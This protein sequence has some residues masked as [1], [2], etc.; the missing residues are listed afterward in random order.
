[1]DRKK[2]SDGRKWA[3]VRRRILA[4][5][6]DR[7]KEFLRLICRVDEPSY[8]VIACEMGVALCTVHE[9]RLAICSRYDI[10]TK[11]GLAIFAIRWGIA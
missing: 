8:Y 1:M 4:S 6:S 11:V 9:Y 7:Q 5:L 10:H 2:K 3:K